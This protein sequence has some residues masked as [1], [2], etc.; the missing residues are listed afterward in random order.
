MAIVQ[1]KATTSCRRVFKEDT[2]YA[3]ARNAANGDSVGSTALVRAMNSWGFT[4]N[5]FSIYRSFLFFPTTM[6]VAGDVITSARIRLFLTSTAKEENTG[7]STLHVVEGVQN[8]PVVVSDFGAHKDKNTSM[9]S[10]AYA[11]LPAASN[12]FW[13]DLNALGLAQINKG[14]TTMFC[15]RLAGDIGSSQPSGENDVNMGSYSSGKAQVTTDA[16]SQVRGTSAI[17]NGVFDGILAHSIEIVFT[18]TQPTYPRFR[19][20]YGVGSYSTNTD[21]QNG[22][23]T[24]DSFTQSVSGLAKETLHQARAHSE[25]NG[26]NDYGS[27]VTFTTTKGY[28]GNIVIDQLIY[29]HAERMR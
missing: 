5:K 12:H 7:Q 26:S 1:A 16:A 6:L 2:V 19:F 11:D 18:G 17:L 23:T 22:L 24:G 14:G 8:D 25:I 3:T 29:Q 4:T 13:I 20:Q 28:L 27:G 10:I 9:G 15:L 21:W